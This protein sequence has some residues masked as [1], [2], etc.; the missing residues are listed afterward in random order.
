MDNL[1]ISDAYTS[2]MYK[3]MRKIDYV[4]NTFIIHSIKPNKLEGVCEVGINIHIDN[5]G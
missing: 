2:D 1:Y 4:N 5:R 3:N